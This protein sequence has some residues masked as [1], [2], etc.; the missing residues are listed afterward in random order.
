LDDEPDGKLP[1]DAVG[2]LDACEILRHHSGT[3]TVRSRPGEGTCFIAL[4]P[5]QRS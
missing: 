2:L 4:L 1:K 5:I 3:L